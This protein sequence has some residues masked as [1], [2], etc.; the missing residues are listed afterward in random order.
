V[1]SSFVSNQLIGDHI[2]KR[3][4]EE[5]D[6]PFLMV[7]AECQSESVIVRWAAGNGNY[8]CEDAGGKDFKVEFEGTCPY[9]SEGFSTEYGTQSGDSNCV[10][11]S[12]TVEEFQA[13][14][15]AMVTSD[16]SSYEGCSNF[17]VSSLDD[18]QDDTLVKWDDFMTDEC[19][20]ESID[21]R[22]ELEAELG[23]G[24]A[25]Y[26]SCKDASG[27]VFKVEFEGTCPASIEYNETSG[28]SICVGT[29][30]TVKEYQAYYD[31]FVSQG[32]PS[33]YEGCSTYQWASSG[34]FS[35]GTAG[36]VM[37][38]LLL[39]TVALFN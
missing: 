24:N 21:A 14:F 13:S 25:S 31:A 30:C 26:S 5:G 27:K 29:S 17:K 6:D 4:L 34:A 33:Y 11:T 19:V 15:D 37:A 28:D 20:S 23:A 32:P 10:G 12:C 1:T 3:T 39:S 2:V 18:S 8:S 36:C 7:S 9:S 16:N 38:G 35:L 22:E